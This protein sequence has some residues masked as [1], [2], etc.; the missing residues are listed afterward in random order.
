MTTPISASESPILNPNE[1]NSALLKE[2]H[3]GGLPTAFRLPKDRMTTMLSTTAGGKSSTHLL[4]PTLRLVT[5]S[6]G[7]LKQAFKLTSNSSSHPEGCGSRL[8]QRQDPYLLMNSDT[9]PTLLELTQRD[10]DVNAPANN[11]LQGA[12][13]LMALDQSSEAPLFDGK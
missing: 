3:G 13:L 2:A 10:F 12:E 9:I 8:G 11:S 4:Y 1:I 5:G 6:P 7:S